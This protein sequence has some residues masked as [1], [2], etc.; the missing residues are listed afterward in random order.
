MTFG[1]TAAFTVDG[2]EQ[3][4]GDHPRHESRW[5]TVDHL[6]TSYALA[7]DEAKL[8]LDFKAWQRKVAK[9]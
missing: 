7:G 9:A 4:L 3:E 6:A 5:G 2:K 1:S 8:D